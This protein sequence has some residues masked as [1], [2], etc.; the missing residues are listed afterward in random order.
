MNFELPD[1]EFD[2]IDPQKTQKKI[3]KFIKELDAKQAEITKRNKKFLIANIY[4][5]V[6]NILL[7][8]VQIL[9]FVLS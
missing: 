7:L 5:G 3:L 4:L 1:I 8:T 6:L 9:L 2:P